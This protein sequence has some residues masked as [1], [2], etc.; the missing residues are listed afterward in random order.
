MFSSGVYTGSDVS[1]NGMKYHQKWV[2]FARTP[3]VESGLGMLHFMD[4]PLYP[5]AL[6]TY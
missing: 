6:G 3:V 4:S 1:P 5:F 2:L